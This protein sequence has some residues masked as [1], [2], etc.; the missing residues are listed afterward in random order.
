MKR[1]GSRTAAIAVLGVALAGIGP[2]PAGAATWNNTATGYWTNSANW[3]GGIPGDG[4]DATIPAGSGFV[5]LDEATSNLTTFT[6]NGGKLRFKGWNSALRATTVAMNV[7][8]NDH[9]ACDTNAAAGNTNRIWIV[10]TNITIGAGAVINV[11]GVGYP[12]AVNAGPGQGP[13]GGTATRVGASHGGLGGNTTSSGPG[14]P[15]VYGTTNAPADPGSGGGGNNPGQGG[16]AG[17]GAVRIDAQERITLQ[18]LISARGTTGSA[19]GAGGSGGGIWLSCRTFEGTA[20]G[21]LRATGGK[22]GA[23]AG[24]GGGGGRIAVIYDPAA[25]TNAALTV[26]VQMQCGDGGGGSE[27]GTLFLNDDQ[28][29]PTKWGH[30]ARLCWPASPVALRMA[31]LSLTN[32]ML[33]FSQPGRLTVTNDMRLNTSSTAS[34]L[35]F[36][37]ESSVAISGSLSVAGARLTVGTNLTVGGSVAMT[38]AQVYVYAAT[39]IPARVF[40]GG[41]MTLDGSTALYGYSSITNATYPDNGMLVEIQ[42]DMVIGST[43]T[44]SWIYPGLALPANTNNNAGSALFKMRHLTILTNCGFNALGLGYAAGPGTKSGY[45]PGG[46]PPRGG[47]T[48]GGAGSGNA[49]PLYGSSN[50]PVQPGSGGGGNTSGADAGGPG[51]GAVRIQSSGVVTLD[52]A[53]SVRGAKAYGSYAAG[54]SGGSIYIRCATFNGGTSGSLNADGGAYGGSAGGGGGGGRIAV[55]AVSTNFTGAVA[56]AG[57]TPGGNAGTIVWLKLRGTPGTLIWFR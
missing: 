26:D 2:A 42:G 37:V 38:N 16:G 14:G 3:T 17:G 32:G 6:Q 13:G 19:Y 8:T 31:G 54:G 45:G 7:G 11:D 25:Q 39:N 9:Y 41:N 52:G 12:G 44:N 36:G 27:N 48:H 47:G 35:K 53:I 56:A 4:A 24:G 5:I 20:T 34:G 1:N 18:G 57:G 50:A 28:A 43:A 30:G 29:L 33:E 51:G 10:C 46:G 40:C 22:G 23:S 15:P 55:E 21:L 49:A